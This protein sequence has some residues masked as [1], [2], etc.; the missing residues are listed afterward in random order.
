MFKKFLRVLSSK[1]KYTSLILL[2]CVVALGASACDGVPSS[3]STPTTLPVSLLPLVATSG[4]STSTTLPVSLLP[5][6]ASSGTSTPEATAV[7]TA[8][9]D[10]NDPLKQD[11]TDI[12]ALITQQE[13]E[14]VLGQS[15][16]SINPLVTPDDAT[17]GTLYTCIYLGSDL[18]VTIGLEDQGTAVDAGQ[19]MDQQLANMVAEDPSTTPIQA[20]GLGDRAYWS[21]AE[22]AAAFTAMKG[23]YIFTVLLGGNIGDPESHKDALL[24]LAIAMAS[25]L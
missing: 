7:P 9:D 1:Q 2:M 25:R 20:N 17:G 16:T 13:A 12:C 18:A 22:H 15:V 8:T 11:L 21:T 10:P 3:S 23:Q 4:N 24:T 5:V 14:A 19:A 6:V